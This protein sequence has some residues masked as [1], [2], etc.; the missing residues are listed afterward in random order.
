MYDQSTFVVQSVES[1]NACPWD[2][3]FGSAIE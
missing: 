3:I 1:L 2:G